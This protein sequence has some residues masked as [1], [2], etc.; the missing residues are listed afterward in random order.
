MKDCTADV[1]PNGPVTLHAVMRTMMA[2]GLRAHYEPPRRLSHEL[3]VLL[4]Q[5]KERER[6][7][8]T[9]RRAPARAK[10]S[11]HSRLSATLPTPSA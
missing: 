8:A 4:L 10:P 6:G 1:K 9:V 11:K 7:T 5:L 3:F 2:D